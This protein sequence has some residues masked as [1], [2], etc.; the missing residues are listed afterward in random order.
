LTEKGVNKPKTISGHKKPM[1]LI[2]R[3]IIATGVVVV[4]LV[5]GVRLAMAGDP[6]L[7]LEGKGQAGNISCVCSSTGCTATFTATLSGQPFGNA[8]LALTLSTAPVKLSGD[9]GCTAAT[10]SGSINKDTFNVQFA[11]QVCSSFQG[12]WFS[13]NGTVQVLEHPITGLAAPRW[14]PWLRVARYTF[15]VSLPKIRFPGRLLKCWSAFSESPDRYP[16]S[17]PKSSQARK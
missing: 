9:G 7:N 1:G 17:F 12:G 14:G 6:T 4:L 5:L 10:G 3:I 16:C 13:I 11:G 2:G 15:L 8:A